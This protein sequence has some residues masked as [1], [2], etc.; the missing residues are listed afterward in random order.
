MHIKLDNKVDGRSTKINSGQQTGL[1][2]WKQKA[3]KNPGAGLWQK[4]T[5]AQVRVVAAW[6]VRWLE[7]SPSDHS[8]NSGSAVHAY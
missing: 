5:P 6:L 1:S 3:A 8:I 4:Q 7:Q 2:W